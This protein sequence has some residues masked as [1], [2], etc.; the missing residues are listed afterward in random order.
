MAD[1]SLA[2][3]LENIIS[4]IHLKTDNLSLPVYKFLIDS[5]HVQDKNEQHNFKKKTIFRRLQMFHAVISQEMSVGFWMSQYQYQAAAF[6][7]RAYQLPS[8]K[9]FFISHGWSFFYV[10]SSNYSEIQVKQGLGTKPATCLL[11]TLSTISKYFWEQI[12]C[13]QHV[14]VTCYHL[15]HWNMYLWD[16][17]LHGWGTEKYM[18]I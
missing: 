8:P 4:H 11:V 17:F 12:Y 5:L 13:S 16:V 15:K 7:S 9:Q 18:R 2:K 1:I 14:S 3:I 10:T 6:F